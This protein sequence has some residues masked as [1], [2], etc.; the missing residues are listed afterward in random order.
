MNTVYFSATKSSVDFFLNL[1]KERK[2]WKQSTNTANIVPHKK[3][4]AKKVCS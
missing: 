1:V 4:I 3:T 2:Y